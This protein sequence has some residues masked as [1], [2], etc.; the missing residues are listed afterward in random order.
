MQFLGLRVRA[1]QGD[2]VAH[3][4]LDLVVVGQ[5]GARRQPQIAHGPPLGGA[6]FEPLLDDEAGGGRG[7]FALG[8]VHRVI[9]PGERN[10]RP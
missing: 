10:R 8:R 7:D 3:L 2:V 1:I 6:V 5:P 9:L 4:G